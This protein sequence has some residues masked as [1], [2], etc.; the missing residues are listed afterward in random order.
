MTF[1]NV[2]LAIR[3]LSRNKLYTFI[4]I[5]GLSIAC[6][7]CILTYWYV[8]NE[9]SFDAFHHDQNRLFRI[10][11]TN[12]FNPEPVKKEKSFFSFLTKEDEQKNLIQTPVI[13]AGDLKGSFPQVENA[14]RIKTLSDIVIRVD[15]ESFR[16]KDGTAAYADADFFK[17]FN[18][19]L[20]SG[21]V[22]Q[23][24]S[25]KNQIVITE[26]AA[27]KYYG[28]S[29][30][31][32][33]RLE[34]PN[35][36]MIF[37]IAGIAKDFPSNSSFQFDII[38]PRTADPDYNEYIKQGTNTFSDLLIVKLKHG[39]DV[40]KFHTAL[41]LFGQ[42][43]YQKLVKSMRQDNPKL[44]QQGID[45]YMR[46]FA[47]AHYN[48]GEGWGHYTSLKNVYQFIC[49]S[50][51][52]LIIASLNYI[53]L[54]LTST[55][56]RSQ[57]VGVRKTIGA[58]RKEI[59][60]QYYAETQI[61][62]AIAVFAGLVLSVTC[63]PLFNNLTGSD[64]HLQNIAPDELVL[65]LIGLAFMLGIIAGI[66][67]AMAMSG[68]KP[69]NIMRG[70]ATY[71]I[72]PV[73]SKVL[74]I[75]QFT[76]CVVLIIT[77][78]VIGKQMKFV[79]TA[80]MGF[81]KDQVV[82]I[83]NPYGWAD[84]Q[85]I[86]SLKELLYHYV[87]TEPV[88]QNIT[89][90]GF[91]FSAYNNNG[92][93]VNGKQIF[94]QELQVDFNYL[95]FNKIPIIK[96]RNFSSAT[97]ADSAKIKLSATQ[98]IPKSSTVGRAI[99]INETLYNML[100]KPKMDEINP[101]MGALIIGV[102]KDYHTDDLTKKIGPAYHRIST[103]APDYFWI[104][105]KA[106]KNIPDAMDK[107]RINW[108]KLTGNSPFTYTFMD[109][110]VKK[111][112]D[113]YLRWMDTIS[114][115]CVIAILISCLGLFGLSA[116]TTINRMK[117]IGIRK[118]LGASVTNLFVLINRSTFALALC[119]FVIATPIALY[120]V[121]EW[122]DNFAYRIKVD[123][124]LFAWAGIATTITAVIAVSYHTIKAAITNP[125]KSLRNE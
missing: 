28:Y 53:L 63:L 103:Y 93:I 65:S 111:S 89:A 123:W 75:M 12:L 13:L 26:R 45:I 41:N 37:T 96:G 110:D 112:Y 115:S 66:Y 121:N 124:S 114:L 22:N 14:V 104:K 40:N 32:G 82:L 36:K 60:L 116:I 29:S 80:Q 74:V 71:R 108:N 94:V 76:I 3:N 49:L 33:R 25:G 99:I 2:K 54:T 107:I 77:T 1:L 56:S 6:A 23:V 34:F 43:Y 52:I 16:E 15:N 81:D 58:N 97:P 109:E 39:V 79:N 120:L 18:Y 59:I 69:L 100:G 98:Q 113:V 72:N 86:R 101:E 73:M 50:V 84:R 7:F 92:H 61:L 19:P 51:I 85:K 67:P 48:Q 9:Q 105:I 90:T 68:L 8:K 57:D 5:S 24:L 4:N 47:E 125:V 106:G 35:D 83:R 20:L 38:I 55:I 95:S 118:I 78:L 64:I 88:L 42:S 31:I 102:C 87:A 10:E 46:P 117:E 11:Q 119:A 44:K 122:L 21:N 27:K 30:P 62:A 91:N 17:V 70:F